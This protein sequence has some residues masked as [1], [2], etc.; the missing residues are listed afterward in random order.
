M[1]YIYGVDVGGTVNFRIV[2]GGRKSERKVGDSHQKKGG[3]AYIIG[4]RSGAEENIAF[5]MG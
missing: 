4:Y 5:S 1:N 2:W 3:G